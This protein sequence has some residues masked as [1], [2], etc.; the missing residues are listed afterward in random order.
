[1]F[2]SNLDPRVGRVLHNI[3]PSLSVLHQFQQLLHSQ[4]CPSSDVVHPSHFWYSVSLFCPTEAYS[5][6]SMSLSLSSFLVEKFIFPHRHLCSYRS[7][8]TLLF[9][10]LIFRPC[11]GC[12]PVDGGLV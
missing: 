6:R 7:S 10:S 8:R 4:S 12:P 5:V 11:P 1:M 9:Q 3:P 2:V